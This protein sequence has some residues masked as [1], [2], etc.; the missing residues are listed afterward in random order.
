MVIPMRDKSN[1]IV[2]LLGSFL[3]VVLLVGIGFYGAMC[4]NEKSSSDPVPEVQAQTPQPQIQHDF[5]KETL[6]AL[7]ALIKSLEQ[8]EQE[9]SKYNDLSD[10]TNLPEWW[11]ACINTQARAN[12]YDPSESM[13][14]IQLE[15]GF[16]PNNI[17]LNRDDNG[18]VLSADIGLMQ[19]NS[20]TAPWLWGVVMDTPYEA[21]YEVAD[22]IFIDERLFDPIAN[23]KMGSW[24]YG[25]LLK[26]YNGDRERANTAYNRGEYGLERW[27]ASRGT[28]RSPYS[29]KV[30]GLSDRWVEIDGI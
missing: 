22:G 27:I 29:A 6:E 8:L 2:A 3:L 17:S 26:Q 5:D 4:I 25:T 18:K 9:L 14:R 30:M 7:D 21:T 23:I 20:E 19:I 24:F 10:K 13:G 15:S 11:L 28:A 1:T 12:G 16:D